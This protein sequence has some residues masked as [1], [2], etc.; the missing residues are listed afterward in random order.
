MSLIT[1]EESED[2]L[3]YFQL[4]SAYIYFLVCLIVVCK[5]WE[6]LSVLLRLKGRETE[7]VCMQLFNWMPFRSQGVNLL[8][9]NVLDKTVERL[10][11]YLKIF[12]NV[13]PEKDGIHLRWEQLKEGKILKKITMVLQ[14]SA[15]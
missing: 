12:N 5:R 10:I 1:S 8:E 9:K 6:W 4:C 3:Y 7:H 11:H 15:R 2:I 13:L 14:T